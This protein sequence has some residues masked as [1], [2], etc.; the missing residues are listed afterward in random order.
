MRYLLCGLL[1]GASMLGQ[2]PTSQPP[3]SKGM[4]YVD[5]IVYQYSVGTNYTVVA[6]AHSAIN[7][8]F[9]ALKV[10]VYNSGSRSISVRPEDL[11]VEDAAAGHV[12]AATSAGDLAARM[13]RTYNMARFAV[14]SA[15][16]DS[17]DGSASGEVLTPQ[18]IEMMRAMGAR[19]SSGNLAM[20]AGKN[21]LYTD[22]PGALEGRGPTPVPPV[23]DQICHLRN[24]EA[25]GRDMLAQLQRQSTPEYVEQCGFRANTI[26]PLGN[27]A[28]VLFYPAG[29]LAQ[30]PASSAKGRK[31][32]QMRV[33]VPIGDENFQFVLPVE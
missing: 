30:S 27:V 33:S 4:F 6:A 26:P 17:M 18:L 15:A 5:G 29:K 23:C 19:N 10:R 31:L 3:T 14:G 21:V 11:L 2:E 9:V 12:V 8:K 16:G 28:G 24:T 7:R 1:L 13:R 32:R 22:T 20:P 25:D